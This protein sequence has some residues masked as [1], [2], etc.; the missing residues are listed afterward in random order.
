MVD[1][2]T[3]QNYELEGPSQLKD[4]FDLSLHLS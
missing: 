3:V 4:S 1:G 2:I